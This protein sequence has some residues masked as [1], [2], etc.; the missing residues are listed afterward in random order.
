MNRRGRSEA[1]GH[2]LRVFRVASRKASGRA[3]FAQ[4]G[5]DCELLSASAASIAFCCDGRQLAGLVQKA[6]ATRQ[7]IAISR[8]TRTDAGH[9]PRDKRPE[10]AKS[11]FDATPSARPASGSREGRVSEQR[12]RTTTCREPAPR[13]GRPLRHALRKACAPGGNGSAHCVGRPGPLTTAAPAAGAPAFSRPSAPLPVPARSA[14]LPPRTASRSS[15]PGSP[16]HHDSRTGHWPS[17]ARPRS[18]RGCA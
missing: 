4:G 7:M 14:T 5:R 6:S 12:T 9:G 16:R 11:M 2:C 3:R 18:A 15:S 8:A 13:C 10:S 17:A 1:R